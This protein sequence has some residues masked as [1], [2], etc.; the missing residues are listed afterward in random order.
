[1]TPKELY[2]EAMRRTD[3]H[4][5][6]GF[7]ELQADDAVW[8][9][10]GA[11]VRGKDEL[12]QWLAPFYTGFSDYRHDLRRVFEHGNIVWAEGTWTGTNDGP[13]VTPDG[14][15]PATGRSVSFQFG[16]SLTIDEALGQGTEVNVYFDQLG[17]LGQLG[18]IPEGAAG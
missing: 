7:L 8:T 13:L 5:L 1:M 18:L 9:V 17:F 14:E 10:P 12:R 6:E 2:L 15:A 3:A 11:T 16:M 4:D